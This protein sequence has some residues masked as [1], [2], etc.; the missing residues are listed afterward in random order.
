MVSR[1]SHCFGWVL[2]FGL[3]LAPGFAAGR[4]QRPQIPGPAG[5]F[6]GE[7]CATSSALDVYLEQLVQY[8]RNPGGRR[9]ALGASPVLEL[10]G[11]VVFEDDGSFT[12][13]NNGSVWDLENSSLHFEPVPGDDGFFDASRTAAD[14][15]PDL[16]TLMVDWQNQWGQ[17]EYR[18]PF[19]LPFGTATYTTAYVTS[20][21]GI[22]FESQ[23]PDGSSD[24]YGQNDIDLGTP[25]IAPLLRRGPWIWGDIMRLYIKEQPGAVTLTWHEQTTRPDSNLDSDRHFQV[26]LESDGSIHMAYPQA[27]P[28]NT[29]GFVQ[30]VAPGPNGSNL[31]DLSTLNAA[32]TTIRRAF[33]AF[34][35]PALLPHEIEDVL[36]DVYGF[37]ADNLDGVAIYQNFYTDITFYAGAY[38]TQG[39]PGVDGIGK[40]NN[41]DIS[42]MHM[43]YLDLSW[44]HRD[45]GSAVSV[46]SHEFGH[47]WLYFVDGVGPSR[48]GAHPAQNSHL[49]A[50]FV[51]W[52]AIDSS[53]MG[54]A[55]WIDNGDG[56]FTSPPERTYYAYAWIELYLMG[57][58]GPGEVLPWWYIGDNADL[59][60]PYYPPVD[61]TYPG[62]V[63]DL[64]I[65]DI[66]NAN[67]DRAPAYPETQRDFRVAIVLL[68]RPENPL[69]PSD[70]V[71]VRHKMGVWRE[72]FGVTVGQR[73]SVETELEQI[74]SVGTPDCNFNGVADATDVLTGGSTDC[75][76]NGVPGE[77]ENDCN[78]N[79]IADDQDLASGTSP[80]CDANDLPDT[81]D[82]ANGAVDLNGN[83]VPDFCECLPDLTGDGAVDAADLAG[84]LGAWGTGP[85]HAADLDGSGA[86]DAADLAILLG[87]WGDCG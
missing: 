21:L 51:W 56:T 76:G 15:D 74:V 68:T 81:C 31:T 13:D 4:P 1:I 33:E 27:Q 50:P 85:G 52:T 71:N 30:V 17:L 54:G 66:I 9:Q 8:R 47:R 70:L 28:L 20:D 62:T 5:Q 59:T 69:Q 73:G 23:Q 42:L 35:F 6:R 48:I 19:P 34:T 83:N 79:C 7:V 24:Q 64:T 84:L 40:P 38:H 26:R 67:G 2:G 46:L 32:P 14:F 63:V 53:P 18:L 55:N 87:A 82:I 29:F 16:G 61:T 45:D 39:N 60:A 49:P 11:L 22:F 58:A 86:V 36:R 25:R 57:L 75:N 3:L 65:D 44:N 10:G 12:D 80:D 37:D 78:G 77:C 43:N 41:L 72:A